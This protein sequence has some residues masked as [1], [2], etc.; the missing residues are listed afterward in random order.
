MPV[1]D[2]GFD[3]SRYQ[4]IPR[5]L[6]FLFNSK[7]SVL[8]IKGSA[9]KARWP[10]KYNGIGGHVEANED[11]LEAALRELKEESGITRVN[12]QLIG[13]IMINVSDISGVA[14]FIF[15]GLY[16]R[17]DFSS[18]QEGN[19]EWIKLSNIHRLPVVEDLPVLIQRI[20]S[21]RLG[22]PIILGKYAY[23]NDGKLNILW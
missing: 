4:V 7:D 12:I 3:A 21:H 16:D 22:D 17:S 18:S 13:Q 2:Q 6:I 23:D 14:L 11:I 5:V 15:S 8:L 9:N 20:K 19:L 1:N 10:G